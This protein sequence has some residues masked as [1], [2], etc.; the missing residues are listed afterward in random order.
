MPPR[1]VAKPVASKPALA[2]LATLAGAM[3]VGDQYIFDLQQLERLVALVAPDS[4][5]LIALHDRAEK[6][7]A[8]VKLYV[9]N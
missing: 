8:L 6:A 3:A 5:E 4:A 7:G 9:D 1:S 2:D